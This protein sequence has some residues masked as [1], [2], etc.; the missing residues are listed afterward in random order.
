MKSIQ[1]KMGC[2]AG[3]RTA[4]SLGKV[5][6]PVTFLVAVLQ[7]TPA[8]DW[9]VS[10]FAPVMGWIGL[11]G[12]AAIPLVLGNVLNLYAAIG[13]V[14]TMEFTVKQVFIIAVMLSFSHNLLVEGALCK[15]I[16]ISF[17]AVSAMRLFMAFSSAGLIHLL[18]SG[19][20]EVA[21]Y[22]LV[23]P[24]EAAV[25]GFLPITLN[26]LET[27]VTGTVQFSVVVFLLMIMIQ[28]LRD[29]RVLDFVSKKLATSMH[30]LGIPERGAITMAAGLLF[31]L[32]FGAGVIIEQAR[33]QSFSKR[34]L[35]VML[36][37]LSGCHAIMEDTLLFVPLGIPVWALLLIRV[38]VA[39]ILTVV[40]ARIWRRRGYRSPVEAKGESM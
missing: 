8:I 36:L 9:A 37:F 15:K 20:G 34:D 30:F 10:L 22:G 5:L 28:V 32:A 19:G 13:A 38:I 27:A 39:I 11:P 33:E 17:L 14:L 29:L 40:V 4:W 2:R 7:H 18:W 12:D 31:G 26:A 23:A 21:R 6:F 24:E 3:L 25:S 35:Y 1:W 16:G